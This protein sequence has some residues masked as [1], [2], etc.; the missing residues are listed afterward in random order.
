MI[1]LL[2]IGAA[3]LLVAAGCVWLY[4]RVTEMKGVTFSMLSLSDSTKS[5]KIS[6]QQGYVKVNRRGVSLARGGGQVRK[7]WGW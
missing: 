7:P 3:S 6:R 4:R 2:L 1:E 5:L